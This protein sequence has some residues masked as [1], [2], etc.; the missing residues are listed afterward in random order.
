MSMAT[1]KRRISPSENGKLT[2]V[3]RVQQEDHDILAPSVQTR[4][5]TPRKGSIDLE[6][7]IAAAAFVE[8]DDILRRRRQDAVY[9]LGSAL[10]TDED[11]MHL[12]QSA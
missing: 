3:Q 11:D 1:P 4:D 5:T 2:P 12:P 9:N 8:T 10:V 6:S 7:A